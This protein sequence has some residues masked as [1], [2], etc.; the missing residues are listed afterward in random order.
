M[1][2]TYSLPKA[3]VAIYGLFAFL[4]AVAGVMLLFSPASILSDANA[5]SP[6]TPQVAFGFLLAAA[7]N[8]FCMAPSVMRTRL[9]AAAFTFL[10]F[11]VLSS[12]LNVHFGLAILALAIYALPLLPWAKFAER[13]AA[14]Q[15]KKPK[16]PAAKKEKKKEVRPENQEQGEV[17][18]FNPNKGFGFILAEDGREVF[19]HFRAVSNGG[20]RSLQQGVKVSFSVRNTERG[21][22]AEQVFIHRSK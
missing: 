6:L 18:W 14:K 13:A 9:H 7:V 11:T 16:K 17:K 4:F 15:H 1:Q 12:S 10:L 19:V 3:L 22:Q 20:R 5:V 8:V 2:T 21:E